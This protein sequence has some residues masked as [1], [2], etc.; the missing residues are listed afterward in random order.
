[1]FFDSD[2]APDDQLVN[3]S[4]VKVIVDLDAQL[5]TGATLNYKDGLQQARVLINNPNASR[6]CGFGDSFR[7]PRE[8]RFKLGAIV[9]HIETVSDDAVVPTRKRRVRSSGCRPAPRGWSGCSCPR[10][11]P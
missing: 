1:M 11:W 7:E 9:D 10:G 6:T 8:R 4:G 2:V 3:Y 5:L